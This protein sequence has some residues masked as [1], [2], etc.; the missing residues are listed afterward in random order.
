MT[1]LGLWSDLFRVKWPPFGESKGHLEEAGNKDAFW[2][3]SM[4]SAKKSPPIS[5]FFVWIGE[6]WTIR[7]AW[8]RLNWKGETPTFY[9]CVFFV[10]GFYSASKITVPPNHPLKNRVFPWKN[11]SILGGKIPLFLVQH[12]FFPR[13]RLSQNGR[14]TNGTFTKK[15][16][17]NPKP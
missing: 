3:Q 11:T 9:I 12:P 17:S 1:F 5:S 15:N 13:S 8:H 7:P 14:S 6:R 16:V 4:W 2:W 10:G